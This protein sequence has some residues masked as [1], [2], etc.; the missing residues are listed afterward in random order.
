M[1]GRAD[2]YRETSGAQP[3]SK[4]KLRDKTTAYR[5]DGGMILLSLT[6]ARARI[7]TENISMTISIGIRQNHSCCSLMSSCQCCAHW[8][9]GETR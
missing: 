7:D 8:R 3:F 9:A 6:E 2:C 5:L 4:A 1:F